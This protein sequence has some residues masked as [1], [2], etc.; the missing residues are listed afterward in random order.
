[1]GRISQRDGPGDRY[2]L[3]VVVTQQ[4]AGAA[5]GAQGQIGRVG[6][7]DLPSGPGDIGYG[8]DWRRPDG[9][10]IERAVACVVVDVACPRGIA[11]GQIQVAV[12][13][14]IAPGDAAAVLRIKGPGLGEGRSVVGIQAIFTVVGHR[15]VQVAVPV[16]IAPGYGPRGIVCH[17]CPKGQKG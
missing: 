10:R 15:Q 11:H 2:K 16:I 8:R 1:M 5:G 6:R 12:P 14:I 9:S 7:T 13:V 4:K 3:A 17:A